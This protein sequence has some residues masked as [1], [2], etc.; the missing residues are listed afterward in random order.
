M[1]LELRTLPWPTDTNHQP[2]HYHANVPCGYVMPVCVCVCVCVC[3]CLLVCV[4][5]WVWVWVCGCVC[6]WVC[7][8]QVKY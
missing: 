7:L 3:L 2:C 6:V 1:K 4:C 8:L 5:V